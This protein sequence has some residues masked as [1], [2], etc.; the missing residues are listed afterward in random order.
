MKALDTGSRKWLSRLFG[1]NVRFDEPMSR[2]TSLRVGGPAE[3]FVMPDSFEGL[4]S[5]LT[6]CRS[7]SHPFLVVGEGTNLLVRDRGIKGIVIVLTG[8]L[9][10]I[11]QKTDE[12]N[13]VSVSAMAG[14]KMKRLCAF[15][16]S[17]GL[18]GM[19]FALG[20]PGTVGGSIRMN[21]GTSRG[22]VG[23]ALLSITLLAPDGRARVI[24]RQHLNIA[25]RSISWGEASEKQDSGA[26]IILEGKFCLRPSNGRHLKNDARK[27]MKTRMGKQP[28][29]KNTAGCIFKN[30]P[31]D[32]PA[33]YLIERAGLKGLRV[34]GAEVSTKH[35]NFI[36][37]KGNASADD[38][39]SLMETVRQKVSNIFNVDLE[40]EVQIVGE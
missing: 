15:A 23:D 14:A 26:S 34:G 7:H 5:L 1:G 22:S 24:E 33:G 9:N 37:T 21:A 18:E 20:I 3:A 12:E 11:T 16:L 27:L 32:K 31:S 30:P 35:A 38:I 29:G 17:R 28:L 39:L 19:N 13:Y 2:H 25:Y 36:V 4:Y 40:N 10:E 8:C 6:W